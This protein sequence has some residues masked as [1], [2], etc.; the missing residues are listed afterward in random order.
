MFRIC[1][2]WVRNFRHNAANGFGIM[3]ARGQICSVMHTFLSD[4]KEIVLYPRLQI[5]A[6]ILFL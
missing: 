4:T 2:S 1:E 6:W 5:A 3:V